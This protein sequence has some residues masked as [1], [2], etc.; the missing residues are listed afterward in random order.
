MVSVGITICYI[1]PYGIF[2][3]FRSISLTISYITLKIGAPIIV[4]RNPPK[5]CNGT[6]F[7][8]KTLKNNIIEGIILTGC[9]KGEH[10][11]IPRIPL[12][13]SDTPF[14]FERLQFPLPVKLAF[15]ITI[16]K[17]QGQ[18][19]KTT[20]VYLDTARIK[21]KISVRKFKRNGN[22]TK[23][24]NLDI[25]DNSG[26]I[27]CAIFGDNVGKLYDI[28]QISLTLSSNNYCY[29]KPEIPEQ[30]DLEKWYNT[31]GN[32]INEN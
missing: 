22:E 30:K 12:K 16:N 15:S 19:L 9:G 21:N 18:S 20:G 31:K 28:F 2:K 3:F 17:S 14:E 32:D 1:L 4:L 26:E 7:C 29:Y 6:R 10:V 27:R 25:I 5:L 11:Y 23:I 8:V 24:F 13:P